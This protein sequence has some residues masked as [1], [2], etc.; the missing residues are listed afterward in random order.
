VRP[1]K[2]ESTYGKHCKI[3]TGKPDCDRHA[4]SGHSDISDCFVVG[5]HI[6]AILI[7][8]YDVI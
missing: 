8:L 7:V 4:Y 2:T 6:Q 1:I 5:M 3:N